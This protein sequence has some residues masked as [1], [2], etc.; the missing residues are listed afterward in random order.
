MCAAIYPAT[1]RRTGRNGLPFPVPCAVAVTIS[2]ERRTGN[3][4]DAATVRPVA[5]TVRGDLY[6]NRPPDRPDSATVATSPET[7]RQRPAV[8]FACAGRVRARP[9]LPAPHVPRSRALWPDGA[10]ALCRDDLAA[11]IGTPDRFAVA[12]RLPRPCKGF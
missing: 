9:D 6:G 11:L 3:R 10:P 2:P 7:G 5:G 8:P 12:S 1:V 4:P